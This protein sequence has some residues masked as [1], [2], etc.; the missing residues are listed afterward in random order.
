MNHGQSEGCKVTAKTYIS[1]VIANHLSPGK[2]ACT[3]C[4]YTFN[5]NACLFLTQLQPHHVCDRVGSTPD[6]LNRQPNF[7]IFG[8]N[9]P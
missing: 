2:D 1:D 9:S 4:A 7:K 6:E 5:F 3:V 8:N